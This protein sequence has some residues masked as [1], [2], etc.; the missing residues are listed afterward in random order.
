MPQAR[1]FACLKRLAEVAE[2]LMAC[3]VMVVINLHDSLIKNQLI[4]SRAWEVV[5]VGVQSVLE[6]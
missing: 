2:F 4:F 5:L 1:Q 6:C 3:F